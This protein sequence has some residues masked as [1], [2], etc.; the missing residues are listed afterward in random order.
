MHRHGAIPHLR[1]TG[2]RV[3]L[4]ALRRAHKIVRTE[5]HRRGAEPLD[6]RHRRKLRRIPRGE[7]HQPHLR[8]LPTTATIRLTHLG[9]PLPIALHRRMMRLLARHRLGQHT[10]CV[11]LHA[12]GEI[13]QRLALALQLEAEVL[14]PPLH[15]E[16]IALVPRVEHQ[17]GRTRR[18]VLPNQLLRNVR[19]FNRRP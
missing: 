13:H 4:G 2:K 7:L 18:G 5:P 19:P 6:R 15:R 11:G 17:L 8:G 9:D 14:H 16:R 1:R 10:P 12:R 3:Q